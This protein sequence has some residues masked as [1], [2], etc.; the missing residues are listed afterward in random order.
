MKLLDASCSQIC[1]LAVTH[2]RLCRY[3]DHWV[4]HRGLTES[5]LTDPRNG[6]V[7]T[8]REVLDLEPYHHLTDPIWTSKN[9]GALMVL[10]N[11]SKCLVGGDVETIAQMST[12]ETKG[13]ANNRQTNNAN[14]N[15]KK[16]LTVKVHPAGS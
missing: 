14:N 4:R 16:L 11:A 6:Q 5:C 7:Q 9:S 3:H 1:G 2:G 15:S 12:R 8:H 10:H 13:P